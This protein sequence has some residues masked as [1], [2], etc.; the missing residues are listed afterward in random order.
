MITDKQKIA[1]LIL[2]QASKESYVGATLLY[3]RR[4][5]SEPNEKP[6]IIVSISKKVVAKATKRNLF[7][8]QLKDYL[9]H[10]LSKEVLNSYYWMWILKTKELTKDH[11]NYFLNKLPEL[12]K[13]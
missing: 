5:N 13:S 6:V 12:F 9:R 11:K 4:S 8:R 2:A 10:N 3:T 1:Q 7:R